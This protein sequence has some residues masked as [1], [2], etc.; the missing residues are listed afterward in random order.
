MA[1]F[2]KSAAFH[3]ATIFNSSKPQLGAYVDDIFGGLV[4]ETSY[5]RALHFRNYICQTGDALTMKINME[6]HKIPLLFTNSAK[7]TDS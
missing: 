2:A 5:R 3:Y 6:F 7:K 4:C 1:L